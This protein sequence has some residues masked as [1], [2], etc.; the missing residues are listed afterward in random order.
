MIK[1]SLDSNALS[2]I[3]EKDPEFQLEIQQSVLANLVRR[4]VKG[5]PEHIQ[6]A[7]QGEADRVKVELAREYGTHSSG[8]NSKFTLN[9]QLSREIKEETEKLVKATF[10]EYLT[11]IKED[12]TNSVKVEIDK[13]VAFRQATIAHDIQVAISKYSNEMIAFEVQ[14]KVKDALSQIK[15]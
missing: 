8:W 11:K 6:L 12:L 15:F 10:N 3:I 9:P 2:A 4:Y 13:A 5:V 7:V 1:I 14:Q